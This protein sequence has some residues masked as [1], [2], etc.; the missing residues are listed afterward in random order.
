MTTDP[1]PETL[2][3]FP[4]RH[5]GRETGPGFSADVYALEGAPGLEVVV[6]VPAAGG[7]RGEGRVARTWLRLDGR[8][9]GDCGLRVGAEGPAFVRAAE[10]LREREG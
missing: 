1:T 10:M 8:D 3:R 2:A 4:R 9:L 6:R 7:W 5:A